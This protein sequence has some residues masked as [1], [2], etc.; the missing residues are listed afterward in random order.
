MA[1]KR[2]SPVSREEAEA[3]AKKFGAV[4]AYFHLCGSQSFSLSSGYIECSSLTQEGLKNVFD[5][6]I[7]AVI[8]PASGKRSKTKGKISKLSHKDKKKD[9]KPKTKGLV[10]F[11]IFLN[12]L[13]ARPVPPV[14]PPA[15]ATPVVE[16]EGST[17]GA[18]IGSLLF[19]S[20]FSDVEFLCESTLFSFLLVFKT[21]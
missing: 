11:L 19:S 14:L 1:A 10:I 4:G 3:V 13:I 9:W 2:Q 18:D 15:A 8:S 12:L 16:V 6:A 21:R 7:R 20:T 17:M 5:T